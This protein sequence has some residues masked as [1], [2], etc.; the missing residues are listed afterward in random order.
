MRRRLCS[1]F[2]P[3][4]PLHF[5][6]LFPHCSELDH[7]MLRDTLVRVSPTFL[8][9]G[10][11]TESYLDKATDLLSTFSSNEIQTLDVKFM[12]GREPTKTMR[13]LAKENDARKVELSAL[14]KEK[15]KKSN[16]LVMGSK[17]INVAEHLGSPRSTLTQAEDD[18]SE[19]S[20]T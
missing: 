11:T 3:K 8:N 14:D 2:S 18:A 15:G 20:V 7:S 9:A 12:R 19:A 5:G 1:S 4:I 16:A 10:E 6:I 17:R 13:I